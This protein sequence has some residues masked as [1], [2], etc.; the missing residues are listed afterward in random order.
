VLV[1]FDAEFLPP[2]TPGNVP[3]GAYTAGNSATITPVAINLYRLAAR[4]SLDKVTVDFDGTSLQGSSF[5]I[6]DIY[7]KNVVNSLRFDGQAVDL[8]S[9][10]NYWTN[11][12]A[13][14]A[15][16][17]GNYYLDYAGNN[18][19]NLIADKGISLDVTV[20]DGSSPLSVGKYWYVYPNPRTEDSDSGTWSPRRTRLVIHAVVNGTIDTYYAFDVPPAGVASETDKVILNNHTY[21]ITNI[22]ITMLGKDNDDNDDKT[23]VGK[24]NIEVTVT[25]SLPGLPA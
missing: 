21:D 7:L 16:N 12:I 8:L 18:I 22:K 2:F 1:A 13:E 3:V 25:D 4:I 14:H 23:E 10:A 5:S 17:G 11:R 15:P 24:A 19:Q 9:D 20:T 6:K